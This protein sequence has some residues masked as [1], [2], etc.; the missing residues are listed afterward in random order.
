MTGMG[1]DGAAVMLEMREAGAW[2]VTQNEATC[3]VFGMPREAIMIGATH[4]EG[5][6]GDL[7]GTVLGHI[8][9]LGSRAL[10]VD[11]VPVL[12]CSYGKI[13]GQYA[14]RVERMISSSHES[15][16]GE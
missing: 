15:P 2:N 9:A 6:I 14:L 8:V 12:E 3:V 7:A 1:K 10:R 11:G 5:A 16:A 13:N 4:A